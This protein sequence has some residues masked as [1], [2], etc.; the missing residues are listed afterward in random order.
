[1]AKN[2]GTRTIRDSMRRRFMAGG[3]VHYAPIA[4][5]LYYYRQ[6]RASWAYRRVTEAHSS[7]S[8][9]RVAAGYEF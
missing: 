2:M 5:R 8:A 9:A 1:M 3:N 4:L 7:A 6:D